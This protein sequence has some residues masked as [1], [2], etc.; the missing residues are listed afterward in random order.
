MYPKPLTCLHATKCVL[1]IG[2]N[3][4]GMKMERCGQIRADLGGGGLGVWIWEE[5]G[6]RRIKTDSWALKLSHRTDGHATY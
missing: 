4:V 6:K 5:V 3:G 2:D 1:F